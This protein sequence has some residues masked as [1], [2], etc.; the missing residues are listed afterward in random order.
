MSRASSK[1]RRVGDSNITCSV[2]VQDIFV[3]LSD[4]KTISEQL[5]ISKQCPALFAL[6]VHFVHGGEWEIRTPDGVSPM[7]PFQ[8]GAL[9]H[10][11]NSPNISI[12]LQSIQ[13]TGNV[14]N[15]KAKN[16]LGDPSDWKGRPSSSAISDHA[17]YRSLS[18]P[19]CLV[20]INSSQCR[21][22]LFNRWMGHEK[23][24][25]TLLHPTSPTTS[26]GICNKKVCRC[27]A[28]YLHRNTCT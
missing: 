22:P 28:L 26:R 20:Y 14:Q 15:I 27:R 17:C 25:D 23:S 4:S 7:P 10:Y 11:A 5:R 1:R 8:G 19:T 6:L 12:F 3:R 24:T 18:E 2:P 21:N 9:D 13:N 16:T